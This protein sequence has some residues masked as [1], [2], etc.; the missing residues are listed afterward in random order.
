MVL[1]YEALL[2]PVIEE[3]AEEESALGRIH[4]AL[5]PFGCSLFPWLALIRVMRA[6][7]EEPGTEGEGEKQN[8]QQTKGVSHNWIPKWICRPISTNPHEG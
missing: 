4:I 1:R 6:A 7:R 2:A 8:A 5:V 3:P